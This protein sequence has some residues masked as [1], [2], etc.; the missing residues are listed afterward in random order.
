LG[1]YF[2]LR[3][4][5]AFRRQGRPPPA[6]DVAGEL[7]EPPGVLESVVERFLEEGILLEDA[8]SPG[9]YSLGRHPS[10]IEL[11][12]VLRLLVPQG[13][14]WTQEPET[15]ANER[16]AA[17]DTGKHTGE[18]TGAVSERDSAP[19]AATANGSGPE[20]GQAR[21]RLERLYSQAWRAFLGTFAGISLER[22]ARPERTDSSAEAEEAMPESKSF[23]SSS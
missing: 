8:R 22:L 11:R 12:E 10:A 2:L 3:V 16:A 21:T 9:C 5:D 1:L 23:D 13:D 14:C 6:A 15:S 4:D 18:E 20:S 17:H 7:G 19:V